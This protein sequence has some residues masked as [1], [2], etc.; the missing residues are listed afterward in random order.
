[1]SVEE[2]Q[3]SDNEAIYRCTN[4]ETDYMTREQADA[5]CGTPI[6]EPTGPNI[7]QDLM[8]LEPESWVL[9]KYSVKLPIAPWRRKDLKFARW[10]SDSFEDADERP[11]TTLEEA[12]RYC[13]EF[14]ETELAGMFGRTPLERRDPDT[15][16][17]EVTMVSPE[18]EAVSLR[19]TLILPHPEEYPGP[20]PLDPPIIFID[21][22][23]VRDPE[24]GEVTREA[25]EL[26]QRLDCFTEISSS[27]TGLH[28]LV[29]A[30]WPDFWP[31]QRAILDLEE[32]GHVELYYRSRVT[33]MT[34]QHAEG[35]PSDRVPVAQGA[36]E[37][38]L[39]E[40]ASEN[41]KDRSR[42][43]KRRQ[44][45]NPDGEVQDKESDWEDW[46]TAITAREFARSD[47]T[48]RSYSQD[49]NG[50]IEG[51]HPVHGATTRGKDDK[52]ST[53]FWVAPDN[54]RWLCWAHEEVS[55]T[56]LA[57]VAVDE[58]I[59]ECK[60]ADSLTEMHEE[61]AAACIAVRER[62]SGLEEKD[63]PM[64]AVLGVA[65]ALDWGPEELAD[66]R[67][68]HVEMAREIIQHRASLREFR[69]RAGV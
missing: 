50:G 13:T 34:W 52:D 65:K 60:D 30:K 28:C 15:G 64:R 45:H 54:E 61:Y 44:D 43:Q 59:I 12:S 19:P 48:F 39:K 5:C 37:N 38:I 49:R 62:V 36:V 42:K 16:Y 17:E 3:I 63:P 10:G 11:E 24:T 41:D 9:W 32:Q 67:D 22:D 26:V 53:N 6:V 47:P 14:S 29:R 23:D 20:D 1:M 68:D 25:W 40:Y 33:G 56:G 7:P 27:G 57:L 4:C 66:L 51:P 55:G 18:H 46:H 31:K 35:T 21:F 69:E 8:E 58:G 2:R